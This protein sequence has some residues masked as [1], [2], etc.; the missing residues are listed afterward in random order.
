MSN[1]IGI[2]SVKSGGF[3]SDHDGEEVEAEADDSKNRLLLFGEQHKIE[4]VM[5]RMI[6]RSGGNHKNSQQFH[7]IVSIASYGTILLPPLPPS[8]PPLPLPLPLLLTPPCH[9]AENNN[10][11][12]IVD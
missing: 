10:E 12:V 6:K 9:S 11:E 1:S 4:D 2:I 8:P 5:R 3:S 7:S